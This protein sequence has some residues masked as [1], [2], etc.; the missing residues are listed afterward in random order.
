MG[1]PYAIYNKLGILLERRM[2]RHFAIKVAEMFDGAYWKYEPETDP[3]STTE[4]K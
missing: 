4:V 1:R 2:T 3:D